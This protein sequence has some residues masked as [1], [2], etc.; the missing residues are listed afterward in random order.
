[1]AK[2]VETKWAPTRKK[3]KREASMDAI[4]KDPHPIKDLHRTLFKD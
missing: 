2:E 4:S 3:R 1:M